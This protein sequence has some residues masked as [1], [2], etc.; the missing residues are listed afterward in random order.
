MVFFNYICFKYKALKLSILNIS[1]GKEVKWLPDK[2]NVSKLL[3][4][5]T[6]DGISVILLFPKNKSTK[7][8]VESSKHFGIS[9]ISLLSAEIH[10]SFLHNNNRFG[11]DVNLLSSR[12]RYSSFCRCII[13]F[14]MEIRLYILPWFSYNF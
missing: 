10:V 13:S 3:K 4:F 8:D 1:F 12:K 2:S 7:E 5:I 14:G 11:N 6:D 9:F